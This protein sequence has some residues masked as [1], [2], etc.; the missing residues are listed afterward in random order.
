[1]KITYYGHSALLVETGNVKVII[2]PFLSGNPNSGISPANISVDAVLLTHGHSDHF[3]DAVE[4][5]KQNDCPIFAVFE[6]AEYCRMKGA[7]VKHMNIGGSHTYA[8]MTV[9]FTQ[10]FHSS[11]IQEGDSWIYAGQPAGILLTIEGKTIFHAGDTAL[12]SD[13]RLIGERN[14]IALAAL[15]IGDMLTMGPDDALLAARWLRADKVIPLHYN[16]F[17]DIAQDG[18]DFCD[19]L[20]QEGV[21]GFPLK[22]GESVEI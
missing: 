18:A 17:P 14:A 10:A 15:P 9:K 16:T 5:A 12:F 2:D 21:E 4:I 13:L 3:G 8:G 22:A 19:R 20:H 11:S 1:M 7:Q 6:L